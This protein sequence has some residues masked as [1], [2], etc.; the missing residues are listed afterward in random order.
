MEEKLL[1]PPRS[2]KSASPRRLK[3][4][5][6]SSLERFCSVA[7]TVEILSDPWSF[8]VLRECFFDT[9]RFEKFQS[10]LG[11]SR[12]T[13]AKLLQ[14]LTALG[15]LR[16][17]LYSSRPPR[18]E[19]R[20]TDM[21]RELYPVML[22]LL[23]FG[24]TWLRGESPPPL[25]L[26]H[27]ECGHDCAPLVVCSHCTTEILP[28]RV[29]YRDGPGAGSSPREADRIR[30]RRVSDPATLERGRPCSVAR[31]L[32][33]L[34]DRWTFLILRETFFGI[35]RYEELRTR[36][37]IATNILRDRLSRLTEQGIL[38]KTLYQESPERF[39]YRLTE[40]GKDFYEPFMV[41]MRWG[42]KW[43]SDSK[44]PLRLRHRDCGRDFAAVVVCDHCH[45]ELDPRQ[46]GYTLRYTL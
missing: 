8:L 1:A 2:T 15:L 16:K 12:T 34:G 14:K 35:R 26:F 40:K 22:A 29:H 33:I 4:K 19:Y 25:Q 39:E 37:G 43:L 10:V 27:Q 5:R 45:Q 17:E 9:R 11:V 32:L 13:L 23:K 36:L 41:M 38:V 30:S 20:F 6:P 3:G 21:G 42:D 7:R 31:T 46:M 24:D 18:F 44:P 28:R